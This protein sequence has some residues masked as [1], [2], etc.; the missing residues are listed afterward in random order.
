[1]E[2]ISAKANDDEDLAASEGGIKGYAE[3]LKREKLIEL[4]NY[5]VLKEYGIDT[6]DAGDFIDLIMNAEGQKVERRTGC[7][8]PGAADRAATDD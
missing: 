5:T 8:G 1:M 6:R 4:D 3:K 2:A 7:L